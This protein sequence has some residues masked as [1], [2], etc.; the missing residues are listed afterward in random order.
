MS[1]STPAELGKVFAARRAK[2]LPKL[3]GSIAVFAA[4][5]LRYRNIPAIPYSFRSSSHVLYFCGPLLPES[6]LV[7]SDRFTGIFL[8]ERT[9]EDEVWNGPPPSIELLRE[10]T[11]VDHVCMLS[12]LPAIA[13]KLGVEKLVA[14]PS[15]DPAT[16]AQLAAVVQRVPDLRG[17][18]RLLAEA[19]SE[20]R[21]EHDPFA[22]G[23][24]KSAVEVTARAFA[25]GMALTEPGLTEQQIRAEMLHVVHDHSMQEAF[26][27]GFSVRGEI[28]HNDSYQGVLADGALLLADFGAEAASGY[29][30]DVTRVWPV[31]KQFS[32]L[33]RDVYSLVLSAQKA[34]I[35][36]IRPGLRF[37]DLHMLAATAMAEGLVAI[38]LLRGDAGALVERGAH[39]LFFPHGLGHLLGLDTHD[40]GD[41]GDIGGYAAGRTRS[42]DFGT[43]YL[44]LDRD[45][46]EGMVVTIE[47]G[48]YWIPALLENSELRATYK[49]CINE[50]RIAQLRGVRGIRIED[51]VLVT[52]EGAEVLT[53]AI[54]KELEAVESAVGLR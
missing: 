16:N 15:I 12:E 51:D 22:I 45:L 39:T 17:P 33:Q 54:P 28:I 2:L 21:I 20:L 37:R 29:S 44:R 32:S 52:K 11:G 5:M 27:G 40:L 49:D 38:G 8:P 24:I 35:A 3:A 13:A 6:V 42:T 43:K 19:V 7:V 34:A 36:A 23:E 47:P 48:W 46:A 31:S 50:I 4:G 10:R 18:D 1:G 14:I 26:V 41:L 30:A 53:K 9:L 25:A